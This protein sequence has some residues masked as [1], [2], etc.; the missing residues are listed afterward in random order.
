[1]DNAETQATFDTMQIMKTNTAKQKTQHEK[2]SVK[3]LATRI[4]PKINGIEP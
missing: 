1:M 2:L 4:P 3:S